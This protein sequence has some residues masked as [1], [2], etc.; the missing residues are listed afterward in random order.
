[1][2]TN[3]ASHLRDQNRFRCIRRRTGRIKLVVGFCPNNSSAQLADDFKNLA[4][5]V[6]PDTGAQ[7]VWRVVRSFD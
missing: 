6:G 2:A 4:A 7:S 3:R 5:F 1:M